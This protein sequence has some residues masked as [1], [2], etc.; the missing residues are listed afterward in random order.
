VF[1]PYR[2]FDAAAHLAASF[3]IYDGDGD[4]TVVVRFLPAVARYV[5]EARWHKSQVLT[6]QRDGSLLARFRLSSTVEIKSWL[7][8]FG[9]N[10]LVLE[11]AEL[12]AAIAAE[13]EHL[14]E[15]LRQLDDELATRR[16]RDGTPGDD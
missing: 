15:G 11:P 2:D 13:L 1:Q 6:P 14:L 9:A 8:S 12:R 16:R 5:E 10:A 7:L 4:V 3:G